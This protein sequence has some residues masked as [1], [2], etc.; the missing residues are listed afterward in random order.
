MVRH[1]ADG[2]TSPG[3]NFQS[4]VSW[5]V[6]QLKGP[7]ARGLWFSAM[8]ERDP[9]SL[10][11]LLAGAGSTSVWTEGHPGDAGNQEGRSPQPSWEAFNSEAEP[12]AECARTPSRRQRATTTQSQII[13][14]NPILVLVFLF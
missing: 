4:S 7:A 3:F 8:E 2:F 11:V 9:A 13:S 10:G 14:Y 5:I 1:P 6:L 12:L